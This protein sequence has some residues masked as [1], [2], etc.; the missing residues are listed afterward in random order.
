MSV[1][2][3]IRGGG[4]EWKKGLSRDECYKITQPSP[5]LLLNFD[6]RNG[7]YEIRCRKMLP[8]F[9]DWMSQQSRANSGY[10]FNGTRRMSLSADI[11]S[12]KEHDSR[13]KWNS[14]ARTTAN[15]DKKRVHGFV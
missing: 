14:D 7:S 11:Y 8:V 3:A 10:S 2:M 5:R 1:K 13:R 12:S 9:H 6:P 4:R 15:R